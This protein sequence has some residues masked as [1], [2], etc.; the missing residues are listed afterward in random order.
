MSK[1]TIPDLRTMKKSGEKIFGIVAWDTHM[2][3]VGHNIAALDR[4]P[5]ACANVAR[6]IEGQPGRT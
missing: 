1:V 2:A 5:D 3:A 4:E 6:Q